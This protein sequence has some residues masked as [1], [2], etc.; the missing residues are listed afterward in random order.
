MSTTRFFIHAALTLSLAILITACGNP[1][2]NKL[3]FRPELNTQRAVSSSQAT[4]VV[5]KMMGMDMNFS[6]TSDISYVMTPKSVDEAGVVTLEVAYESARIQV[7]GMESMMQNVPNMPK[8]PGMD[9]LYGAKAV[10]KA[11][12]TIN[13]ETF[14]ARVSR[15]GEVL[16]VEGA[17]AIADKLATACKPPAH[18]P[19]DVM[20][21]RLKDEFGNEGVKE[22]LEGA[23]IKAPDKAL[24]PGDTWQETEDRQEKGLHSEE[25]YTVRER[26]GGSVALDLVAQYT[27]DASKMPGLGQM[28]G[29]GG[30]SELK[31]Q[32]SGTIKVDDLTGW[33][34]EGVSTGKVSGTAA[35]A[36]GMQV[37]LEISSKYE[38]HSYAK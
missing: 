33:V 28:S 5:V 29:S 23:F 21:E 31:G 25:T 6:S 11:L 38:V 36:P 34:L 9:D 13:G 8:V 10:Q 35:P 26:V 30:N 7:T 1:D 19:A 27:M 17:D 15:Q 12:D 24:N 2:K 22:Y 37:P 20:K 14:T 3:L 18:I 32:G 4:N 16:A